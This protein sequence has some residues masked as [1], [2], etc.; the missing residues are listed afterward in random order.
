M[1]GD[2]SVAVKTPFKRIPSYEIA[3]KGGCEDAPVD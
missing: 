3:L 1:R 2:D